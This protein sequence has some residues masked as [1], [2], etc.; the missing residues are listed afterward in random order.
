MYFWV[1]LAHSVVLNIFVRLVIFP[2]IYMLDSAKQNNLNEG[3]FL[4]KE[5]SLSHSDISLDC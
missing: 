3:L 4:K 2:E 1:E 5:I